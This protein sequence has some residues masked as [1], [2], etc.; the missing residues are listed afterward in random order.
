LPISPPA[1]APRATD[2][3]SGAT[4]VQHARLLDSTIKHRHR[5]HHHPDGA[6][7]GDRSSD[8]GDAERH[9]QD[10]ID[11]VS[12]LSQLALRHDGS[13]LTAHPAGP[14]RHDVP[15]TPLERATSVPGAG[16]H[17]LVDRAKM[18]TLGLLADRCDG[19]ALARLEAG[20]DELVDLWTPALHTTSR[21]ELVSALTNTDDSVSDVAVTFTDGM[22]AGS[23]ALLVWLATGRFSRPAFFDDE[24]LVEPTGAVIRFA[25]ATSVT[26][27]VGCRAERIR[28]YYDRL[29][30]VEQMVTV[31]PSGWRT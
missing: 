13:L 16:E 29:S 31:R 18:L 22:Q 17:G 10:D 8:S 3:S 19:S 2:A 26:F 9:G 1:R 23:T 7:G 6:I 25:G 20:V 4:A 21:Y 27:T 11:Q 12:L 14:G 30:V 5:A 28:C 15:T 24:H